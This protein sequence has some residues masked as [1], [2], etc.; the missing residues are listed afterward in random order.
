VKDTATAMHKG[1][2]VGRKVSGIK[3]PV[4]ID[5][6]Q[7]AACLGGEAHLAQVQNVLCDGDYTGEPFTQ[8]V[9]DI[10]GEHVRAQ[11]ARRS[12]LHN[13]KV[14]PKRWVVKRSFVWLDKTGD[15]GETA[16][17]SSTPVGSS[18]I[19]H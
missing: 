7:L 3:R 10:P 18:S 12:E 17:A 5:I 15:C 2:N 1:D 14:M 11:I 4:A 19:G 6:T 8:R 13:F 9:R 16:N